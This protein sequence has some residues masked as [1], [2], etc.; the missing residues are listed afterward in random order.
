MLTQHEHRAQPLQSDE[1]E[2]KLACPPGLQPPD[3]PCCWLRLP[4]SGGKMSE[5][6]QILSIKPIRKWGH[7]HAVTVSKEVRD[8][9]NVK[10]GDK[11]AFRKFGRYV[12]ILAL[13]GALV[14]PVTKQEMAM[15][16][17]ALGG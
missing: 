7:S 14:A 2:R 1:R 11:I 16:R 13:N 4:P 17:A 6:P 9:L 10:A 15:A 12:F 8:A 3:D 5:T